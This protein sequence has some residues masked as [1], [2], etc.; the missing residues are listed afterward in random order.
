MGKYNVSVDMT[1]GKMVS[2]EAD[3]EYEAMEKVNEMISNDP[4]QYTNNYSHY[5]THSVVD[6]EPDND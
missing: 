6:A 3:N 1:L 5:V 2:V 4:Y